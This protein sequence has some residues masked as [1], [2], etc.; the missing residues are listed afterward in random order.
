MPCVY[1]LSSEIKITRCSLLRGFAF[2]LGGG[3]VGVGGDYFCL[4]A[5]AGQGAPVLK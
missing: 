2:I 3:G 4:G 1:Q 5:G